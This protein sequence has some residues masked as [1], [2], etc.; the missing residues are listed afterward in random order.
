MKVCQV[1]H[2]FL[3]KLGG[4]EIHV[5]HLSKM[6]AELGLEV[7]VFT[8]DRVKRP[9]F[10]RV[11]NVPVI[12]L[13][14]LSFPLTSA[15]ADVNVVYW[16]IPLLPSM[17]MRCDA[18]VIHAHDYFHLSS[19]MSAWCS[20]LSSKPLVLSIHSMP[21]FF[22]VTKPLAILEK[23]YSCSL[24]KFNLH[25]AGKIIFMSHFQAQKFL[26]LGVEKSKIEIIYPSV[27]VD[28][29]DEMLNDP[30]VAEESFYTRKWGIKDNHVVLIIGRIEKRKGLQHVIQ[31]LPNVIKQIP[32]V[33][34]II[35]GPDA[36]YIN[37]LKRMV[38][39]LGL[40]RYVVFT[41]ALSDL[42]MKKAIL[43]ADVFVLPSEQENFPEVTLKAAYLKK[44]IVASSVGG[45]PEFIEDGKNGFLVEVG[46]I[47]EISKATMTLLTDRKL[48][49]RLGE[50][51]HKRV[52]E[53][54]TMKQMAI[55]TAK[56][57]QE[58]LE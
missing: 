38:A 12:R 32:D 50:S 29:F 25:Q 27:D 24:G 1:T 16:V 3:P 30:S 42:E 7:E 46:D 52:L 51:A 53:R 26:D 54:H 34:L 58:L 11:L 41:G 44:P 48:A 47:E 43:Y 37:D 49:R 31:A 13:P 5:F 40:T 22:S 2:T 36:G 57:Y 18:D 45:I 4:R 23:I 9:T 19:D 8:G 33:K 14:A 28:E 10:E 15:S 56:I 55:E 20:K 21:D 6:L 35:V 39:T 17:L